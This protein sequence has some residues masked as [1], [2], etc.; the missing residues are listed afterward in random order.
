LLLDFDFRTM[1]T[2]K[3]KNKIKKKWLTDFIPLRTDGLPLHTLH[4]IAFTLH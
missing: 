3:I 4:C 1:L 2:K